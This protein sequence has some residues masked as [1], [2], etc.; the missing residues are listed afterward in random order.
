MTRAKTTPVTPF[1]INHDK[2]KWERV[3]RQG[4]PDAHA[5][6][7]LW[8]QAPPRGESCAPRAKSN[9]PRFPPQVV[10]GNLVTAYLTWWWGSIWWGG[11]LPEAKLV[12]IRACWKAGGSGHNG[13]HDNKSRFFMGG[14]RAGE[15]GEII[16]QESEEGEGREQ[17]SKINLCL[18]RGI[19]V[20]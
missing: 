5:K 13:P 20:K 11:R 14:E 3:L 4:R 10:G 15:R 1:I 2:W 16:E 19:K 9:C 8:C 6:C 12:A 7:R 17:T 18:T